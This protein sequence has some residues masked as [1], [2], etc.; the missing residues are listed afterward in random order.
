MAEGRSLGL[1]RISGAS[2]A[3]AQ[4]A[5]ANA[6]PPERKRSRAA[7]AKFGPVNEFIDEC[8]KEDGRR[9]A[10]SDTRHT[11]FTHGCSGASGIS[12]QRADSPAAMWR[13][14]NGNAA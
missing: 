11:A 14:G 3:G 12:D 10:S 13:C 6:L 9:R 7:A 8:L 2:P 1:R 4:Q 5:I